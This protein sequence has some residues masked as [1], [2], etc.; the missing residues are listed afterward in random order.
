MTRL[1][2]PPTPEGGTFCCS[3]P[4]STDDRRPATDHWRPATAGLLEGCKSVV[5]GR[6]SVVNA[7]RL[8]A[9]SILLHLTLAV[10]P[11][12]AADVVGTVRD[13]DGRALRDAV[14]F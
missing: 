6:W 5:G 4:S 14:V 12:Q 13:R 10:A 1:L 3:V 11:G 8:A 2:F 7:R 9:L